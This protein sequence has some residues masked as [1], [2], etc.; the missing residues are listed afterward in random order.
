MTGCALESG[1]EA[2]ASCSS[3]DKQRQGK[4]GKPFIK[5]PVR[6]AHRRHHGSKLGKTLKRQ[7]NIQLARHINQL[8]GISGRTTIAA[9]VPTLQEFAERRLL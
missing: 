1:R 8:P 5:A 6:R 2:A 7:K 4:H 9:L 3:A